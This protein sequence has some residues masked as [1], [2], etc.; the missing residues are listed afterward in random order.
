MAVIASVDSELDTNMRSEME[1]LFRCDIYP[2]Q[3]RRCDIVAFTVCVRIL[4]H[5]NVFLLL[6]FA[7]NDVHVVLSLI[8]FIF[9]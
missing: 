1:S 8:S 2:F 5:P 3:T 6:R 4:S 9:W 7:Q